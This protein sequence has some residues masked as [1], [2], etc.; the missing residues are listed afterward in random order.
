MHCEGKHELYITDSL[1]TMTSKQNASS[2]NFDIKEISLRSET[3]SNREELRKVSEALFQFI[4]SLTVKQGNIPS[5]R[6]MAL[7]I[8][9]IIFN[10]SSFK[11]VQDQ[12]FAISKE[13]KDQRRRERLRNSSL[14]VPWNLSEE[15]RQNEK[16]N[17]L[18]LDWLLPTL[19]RNSDLFD[20]L[21]WL[22]KLTGDGDEEIKQITSKAW[23]IVEHDDCAQVV[24]DL[25]GCQVMMNIIMTLTISKYVPQPDNRLQAERKEAADSSVVTLDSLE[26]SM[27]QVMAKILIDGGSPSDEA[28]K[29]LMIDQFIILFLHP[30]STEYQNYLALRALNRLVGSTETL[31]IDPARYPLFYDELAQVTWPTRLT[32][33]AAELMFDLMENS[34][35]QTWFMSSIPSPDSDPSDSVYPARIKNLM[36]WIADQEPPEEREHFSLRAAK[37]LKLQ[38]SSLAAQILGT[39]SSSKDFYK[40][41]LTNPSLSD[42]LLA[43]FKEVTGMK[44][45]DEM[46]ISTCRSMYHVFNDI[47]RL[48]DTPDDDPCNLFT[49]NRFHYALMQM[50]D[51]CEEAIEHHWGDYKDCFDDINDM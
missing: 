38:I 25:G 5:A 16:A 31:S 6:S 27:I 30:S 34:E 4:K 29:Q 19:K 18:V 15:D 21:A 48:V 33:C 2:P 42:C 50:D 24:A 37:E 13:G 45:D 12:L 32:Q 46:Y 51:Y 7:Q 40:S 44:S 10:L 39:L 17:K 28:L 26:L 47:Y 23:L 11:V 49:D 36:A 8:A 35:H 43:T 9:T 41:I 3:E 1:T 20:T 14:T 22:S